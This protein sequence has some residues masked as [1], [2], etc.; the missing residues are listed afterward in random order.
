MFLCTILSPT[1]FYVLLWC[2]SRWGGATFL[3]ARKCSTSS[4]RMTYLTCFT[5]R[6]APKKSKESRGRDS[7]SLKMMSTRLSAKT[8]LSLVSLGFP[9]HHPLHPLES[10]YIIR[11]EKCNKKKH[12]VFLFMSYIFIVQNFKRVIPANSCKIVKSPLYK[13]ISY[14]FI[15]VVKYIV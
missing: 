13:I 10:L 4:W 2:Q 5:L 8:K 14:P 1:V 7:L 6:R 12:S 15:F 9:L 11:L 3:I